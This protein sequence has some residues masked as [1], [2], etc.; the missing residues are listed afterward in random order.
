MAAAG[1]TRKGE[2]ERHSESR[3]YK[4]ERIVG[5]GKREESNVN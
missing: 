4:S 3:I 2:L 1:K 5:V